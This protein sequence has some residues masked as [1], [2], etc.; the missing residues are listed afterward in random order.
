MKKTLAFILMMGI[1]AIA[2]E[3]IKL[4]DAEIWPK[5][6]EIKTRVT[7]T[8]D[9]FTVNE[10]GRLSFYSAKRFDVDPTKSYTIS[11][12]VKNLGNED[13]MV[14]LGFSAIDAKNIPI[15][16]A[17]VCQRVNS[18]TSLVNDAKK[19]DNFLILKDASA[20]NT[21]ATTTA[22]ALDAKEDFSDMPNNFRLYPVTKIEKLEDGTW[23]VETK[24]KLSRDLAAG[25][26]VRQHYAG[27]YL[28][29]GGAV[30]LKPGEERVL[31]GT[32]KGIDQP[33]SY[34]PRKWPVGTAK[35][36]VV[37]LSNHSH[38]KCAMQYTNPKIDI[39]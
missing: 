4:N 11:T 23:R 9:G 33:G 15:A 2:A 14:Y 10:N 3:T 39:E 34:N 37:I 1:A 13:T 28:Y 38:K 17:A 26:N 20:W 8:E 29:T 12:T 16:C 6:Q 19:G 25:T 21:T 36:Q 30:K 22:I 5:S 32:I 24:Q 7:F 27:G 31:K 35:M 18:F